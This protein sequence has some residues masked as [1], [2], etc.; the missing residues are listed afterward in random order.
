MYRVML[1]WATQVL[2]HRTSYLLLRNKLIA[3]HCYLLR[4]H[5]STTV[6]ANGVI[7]VYAAG[8]EATCVFCYRVCKLVFIV[9]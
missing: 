5:T 1:P 3:S 4:V 9:T 6:R 2:V 7:D 8:D